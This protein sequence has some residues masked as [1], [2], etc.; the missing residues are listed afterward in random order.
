MV[1]AEEKGEGETSDEGWQSLE[2][3]LEV[4]PAAGVVM[5][6]GLVNVS[7][8]LVKAGK[9][10]RREVPE[11]VASWVPSLAQLEIEDGTRDAEEV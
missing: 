1:H 6:V 5:I 8:R 2:E 4:V 7:T 10:W 11:Y 3:Q 9:G